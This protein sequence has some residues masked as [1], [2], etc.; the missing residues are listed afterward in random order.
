MILEGEMD[1][2]SVENALFSEITPQMQVN[3]NSQE[4]TPINLP[5][6]LI[7]KSLYTNITIIYYGFFYYLDV[8]RA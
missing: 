6:L 3:R 8:T 2:M 7:S 5:R 4:R 1:A